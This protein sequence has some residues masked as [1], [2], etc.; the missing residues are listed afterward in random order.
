VVAPIASPD[1]GSKKSLALIR[2]SA[3]LAPCTRLTS[4]LLKLLFDH[5]ALPF[6]E[7]PEEICFELKAVALSPLTAATFPLSVATAVLN[8]KPTLALF[9]AVLR[10]SVKSPVCELSV[11]PSLTFPKA[12]QL[13]MTWFAGPLSAASPPPSLN[14]LPSP[15]KGEKPH[16]H[17]QLHYH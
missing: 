5:D 3:C 1:F 4:T 7:F 2:P 8:L 15:S 16:L 17:C 12:M 13:V 9:H 10:L 14:P 6:H 11:K